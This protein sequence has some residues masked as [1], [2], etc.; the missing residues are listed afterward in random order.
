MAQAISWPN[1]G[2]AYLVARASILQNVYLLLP[3]DFVR[4]LLKLENS[5]LTPSDQ[6]TGEELEVLRKFS[7]RKYV[8]KDK[9][10]GKT[11]FHDL[12]AQT[13]KLLLKGLRNL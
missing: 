12:N 11:F 3:R 7:M 5:T 2:L 9:V 6:F 13:R 10:A 1:F 8:K 4:K